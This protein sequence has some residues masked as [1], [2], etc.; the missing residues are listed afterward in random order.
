MLL[1]V[2]GK[3]SNIRMKEQG[4]RNQVISWDLGHGRHSE[5]EHLLSGEW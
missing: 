4:D 2:P 3:V 5:L 1:D